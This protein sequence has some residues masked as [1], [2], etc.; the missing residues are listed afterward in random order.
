M[1]KE[2][3]SPEYKLDHTQ[4]CLIDLIKNSQ[5]NCD[6]SSSIITELPRIKPFLKNSQMNCDTYSF[7]I[8]KLL[9]IKRRPLVQLI[10]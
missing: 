8:D 9:I 2:S 10:M 7:I 5:M 1:H 6:T 3:F 4:L